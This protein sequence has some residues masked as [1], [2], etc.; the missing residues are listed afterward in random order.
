VRIVLYVAATLAVAAMFSPSVLSGALAAAASALFES[1]PFLL[2]GAVLQMLFRDDRLIAYAGCGCGRGPSARSVPAALATALVFGIWVA[3]ARLMAASIVAAMVARRAGAHA[4]APRQTLFLDD[5]AALVVAALFA[6]CASQ[7]AAYVDARTLLPWI[8]VAAGLALGFLA[9]PCALGAVAIG[10]ALH[11][12]SPQ[13]SAAFLCV[14][15]IVDL[16]AL[17]GRRAERA[18]ADATAYLTLAIGLTLVA[19]RHGD[20]LVR[21]AIAPLLASCAAIAFA[22]AVRYRGAREPKARWAPAIML[23]GALVT[24]PPPAYTA[25]ETTLGD[26]FDGERLDFTGRLTRNGSSAALVRYAI[27]CCRADAAPVVIRLREAPRLPVGTWVRASGTIAEIA[28]DLRLSTTHLEAVAP[29]AD[30]FIYR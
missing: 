11:A 25:T 28:D 26:I 23:A 19:I 13:A 20:A 7:L 10:A 1:V 12:R 16:Q 4:C 21:P 29:P 3:L 24:A 18:N 5:L 17:F 27:T 2:A 30:P 8:A 14:A 6:G 9:T 15:G 22:C